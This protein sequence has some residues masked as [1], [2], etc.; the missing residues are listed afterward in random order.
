MQLG[1]ENRNSAVTVPSSNSPPCSPRHCDS[2]I[3]SPKS[4]CHPSKTLKLG[5]ADEIQG[6]SVKSEFQI[7]KEQFFNISMSHIYI[8]CLSKIQI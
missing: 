5:L 6:N 3:V 7:N 8:Y 1:L 2:P 4:F